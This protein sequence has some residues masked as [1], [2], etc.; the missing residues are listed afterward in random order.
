MDRWTAAL[1]VVGGALIVLAIAALF[2]RWVPF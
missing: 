2:F 1:S